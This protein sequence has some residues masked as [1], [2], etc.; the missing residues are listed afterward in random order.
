MRSLQAGSVLLRY[1]VLPHSYDK[2]K[3]SYVFIDSQS[4]SRL[5]RWDI[6]LMFNDPH[7]RDKIWIIFLI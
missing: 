6:H 5:M 1:L 3:L 7:G 4:Q 2:H